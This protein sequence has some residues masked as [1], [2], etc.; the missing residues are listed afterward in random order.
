M[1]TPSVKGQKYQ[2]RGCSLK[3]KQG[4]DIDKLG[5]VADEMEAEVR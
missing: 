3:L 4:F 2:T 5:Q 1:D